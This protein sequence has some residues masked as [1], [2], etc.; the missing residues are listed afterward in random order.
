M[1]FEVAVLCRGCRR[2]VR[3]RKKNSFR[4]PLMGMC[5][6]TSAR[7]RWRPF[8]NAFPLPYRL[9]HCSYTDLLPA[10]GASRGCG[11]LAGAAALAVETA[12]C[13]RAWV[14]RKNLISTDRMR[15]HK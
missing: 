5:E 11:A 10:M 14:P 2:A 3:R 8:P 6:S 7:G 12:G 4:P 1:F 13:V 9:C 15:K